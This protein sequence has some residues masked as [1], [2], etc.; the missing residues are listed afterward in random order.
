MTPEQL[1]AALNHAWMTFNEASTHGGRTSGQ[2]AFN[3]ARQQLAARHIA[4]CQDG[5][6]WKLVRAEEVRGDR[7]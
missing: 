7:A 2:K 6:K 5:D 3:N 1:I 4:V